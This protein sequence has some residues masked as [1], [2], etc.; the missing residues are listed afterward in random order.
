MLLLLGVAGAGSSGQRGVEEML[1]WLVGSTA[2]SCRGCPIICPRW[3]RRGHIPSPSPPPSLPPSPT[4]MT[5]WLELYVALRR[6]QAATN[7]YIVEEPEDGAPIVAAALFQE[8]GTGATL[9]TLRISYLLPREWGRLA[10]T[11]A[12][13]NG[14]MAVLRVQP[15]AAASSS[16]RVS[17]GTCCSMPPAALLP[18]AHRPS[19]RPCPCR[20]AVRVCWAAG[21][22]WRR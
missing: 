20:C 9:V 3:R 13:L 21:G 12:W 7:K 15:G 4:A 22:V 18:P 2:S 1:G 11:G 19:T 5:P 16:G 10:G 6:T 14:W 17:A 8:D